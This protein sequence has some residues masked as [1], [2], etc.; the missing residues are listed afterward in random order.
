MKIISWNVAG[1]RSI[2]R[3]GN[4]G[5][6]IETNPDI[7]CLQETKTFSHQLS[8]DVRAPKGYHTHFASSQEKKGY[9]GVAVF[10]KEKPTKVVFGLGIDDFDI[11]GRLIEAHFS[12]FVLFNIYFPNSGRDLAR[13]PFRLE[14]NDALFERLEQLKSNGKSII[15]TGD[16]N[17]AHEEIDIARPKAN[18]GRSGFHPDERAWFDEL[19]NSGYVDAFRH[20]Y[21]RKTGSYTYWDQITRARDR[22]VGWRIDYFV[23]SNDLSPKIKSVVHN[24]DVFGSDHCPVTFKLSS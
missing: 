13:L 14:F 8:E 17:V 6:L 7:F 3:N 12:N 15:I 2:Y 19:L 9:S 22:N 10:S 24:S 21:P 1:L 5:W 4:W 16:F 18:D 23:V 11:E 20:L